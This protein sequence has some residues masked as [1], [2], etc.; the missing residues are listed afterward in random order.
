MQLQ[1]QPLHMRVQSLVDHDNHHDIPKRTPPA[2]LVLL[3]LL[4]PAAADSTSTS[5]SKGAPGG[6]SWLPLT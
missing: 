3:L 5:S 4:V 1:H 6:I 2:Q